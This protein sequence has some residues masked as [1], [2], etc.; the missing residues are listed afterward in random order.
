MVLRINPTHYHDLGS[1]DL[2]M[3]VFLKFRKGTV[4][5]LDIQ[6]LGINWTNQAMAMLV[7]YF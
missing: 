4:Q 6:F 7:L 1:H 2:V 5:K 3:I